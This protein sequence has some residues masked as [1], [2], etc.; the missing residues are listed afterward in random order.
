MAGRGLPEGLEAEVDEHV[1]RLEARTG[2]RFGSSDDPLLVSVRSGAAVSMP[3]MMD[4]ILN[5][6]LE[7][8]RGRGARRADGERA[9]R[10][11]LLPAADPDVRR[12]GGRDRRAPLR[13][14]ALVAEGAARRPA[15]HGSVG[16]RP[17]RARRDVQGD[18]PRGDRRRVRRGRA[19]AAAA[20]RAGG[21]RLVGHA[22]GAGLPARARHPRRSRD[23]G[24]RRADGVRQQ[25]RPL[26]HGRRVH[27][28]PVDRRD[29]SLRR[30]PGER[31]G[32]GRRGRDPH[33]AADRGDARCP[34]EG[35]RPA[36][37]DDAPPRGALP[38]H[39]GHRVHG[40]G[41]AAVSAADALGEAH[42]GRC[43]EGG[44]GDGRRGADHPRGGGRPHRSGAAR[45]AAAPDDR[46]DGGARGRRRRA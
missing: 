1:R 2:K 13:E 42:R 35:V 23:R 38:R 3:G 9:V 6:G 22:A 44:G 16:R 4:T 5:L 36:G 25:G 17:A 14:R 28:R 46:P 10:V 24:Q 41:R 21:V 11:R 15:R 27:P 26:G 43:A 19:R 20:G 7:R 18:L 30:V 12:G 31:A 33:A 39:A 40:R 32:R 29:R 34:A 8:R 45:P 37:R